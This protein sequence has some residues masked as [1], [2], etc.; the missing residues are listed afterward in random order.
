MLIVDEYPVRRLLLA[1]HDDLNF[2]RV[3]QWCP[4]RQRRGQDHLNH[5]NMTLLHKEIDGWR[6]IRSKTQAVNDHFVIDLMRNEDL[7]I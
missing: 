7:V 5:A 6:I 3:K 4:G 2:A 1:K